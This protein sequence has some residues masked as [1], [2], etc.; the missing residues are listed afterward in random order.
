[1]SEAPSSASSTPTEPAPE[2]RQRFERAWKS[3]EPPRLEEYLAPL[4]E[5]ERTEMLGMLLALEM[6]YRRLGG[7]T[8]VL[9]EYLQRF[10]ADIELVNAVFLTAGFPAGLDWWLRSPRRSRWTRGPTNRVRRRRRSPFPW[11]ATGSRPGWIPAPSA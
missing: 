1:M 3:E 10:P 8:I 2:I 9:D 11:A 5:P 6:H 7:E 4:P